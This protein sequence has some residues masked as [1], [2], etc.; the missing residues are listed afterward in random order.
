MAKK[1][2]GRAAARGKKTK[3]PSR[4]SAAGADKERERTVQ[5]QIYISPEL[6]G[7]IEALRVAREADMRAEYG[8]HCNISWSAYVGSIL[9]DH[10][11]KAESA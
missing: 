7:Q 11:R 2:K 3:K 8:A 9:H 4:N 5:R 1:R 10:C 6:V